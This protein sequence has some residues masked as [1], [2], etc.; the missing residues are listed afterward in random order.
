MDHKQALSE[1]WIESVER[2]KCQ[3]SA[4]ASICL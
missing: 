3:E 4:W 2:T 1:A